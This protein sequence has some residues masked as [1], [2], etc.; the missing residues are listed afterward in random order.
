MNHILRGVFPIVATTFNDDGSLDLR[1]QASLVAHLLDAGVHGLGLFGNAGEGYTLLPEERATLLKLILTEVNGRV[2]VVVSTGHSGTDAAVRLSREA[3]DAGASALMILPPHFF[4]PDTDGVMYYFEAISKGVHIPIMVQ[5][6]PLMTQVSL[7]APFLARLA[8]EVEHVGY[9]KIEAPPTAPKVSAVLKASENALVA[10]GGLNGQFLIEEHQRGA[11]GT[12]PGSDMTALYVEVWNKLQS[13]DRVAAWRI[14]SRMLPLVR[15]ELQ[16][17]MGVSAM[18]HNLHA[19]GV[20]RSTRV[21]HPA[22]SLD[23]ISLHELQTL[24][25]L[26]QCDLL[27]ASQ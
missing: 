17:G 5:D 8:R 20:I 6:A 11:L 2:P 9:V 26:I 12:M 15:F 7:P 10:F 23:A 16:P 4:R 13:G 21:R 22:V 1:S 27:A 19:S 14:F 24:R 18:K 25:S 3:E